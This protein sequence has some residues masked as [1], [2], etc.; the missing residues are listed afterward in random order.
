MMKKKLA[1]LISNAGSGTNLQ[2]VIDAMQKDSLNAEIKIVISGSAN[3]I[4][5]ERAKKNKIKTLVLKIGNDGE[6]LLHKINPDYIVLAGWKRIIS[7]KTMNEFKNR[8]INIHPGLIP[9]TINGNV[10]NP[11]N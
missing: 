8:I 2:A 5:L 6:K 1:I 11:D 7:D 3:A 9:D 10:K 4:G